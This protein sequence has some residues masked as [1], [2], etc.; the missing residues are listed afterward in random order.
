MSYIRAFSLVL[1]KLDK[2]YHPLSELCVKFTSNPTYFPGE[3]D[4][5]QRQNW[6]R[7]WPNREPFLHTP[8]RTWADMLPLC[9]Q[10]SPSSD[11]RCSSEEFPERHGHTLLHVR[12][13]AQKWKTGL[14]TERVTSAQRTES[15]QLK[16][17]ELPWILQHAFVPTRTP[18][19]DTSKMVSACLRVHAS[20]LWRAVQRGRHQ[21]NQW[22]KLVRVHTVGNRTWGECDCRF[23]HCFCIVYNSRPTVYPK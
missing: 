14:F 21:G 19:A 20:S 9:P 8:R 13:M 4:A 11:R 23:E 15:Y 22:S 12:V 17:E 10:S 18:H 2:F 5:S 6:P 7:H 3:V 16:G 1:D